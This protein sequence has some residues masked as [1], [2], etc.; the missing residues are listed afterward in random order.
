[1]VNYKVVR[2]VERF[3]FPKR[4]I[5]LTFYV[6]REQ[7]NQRF[8]ETQE[9]RGKQVILFPYVLYSTIILQIPLILLAESKRY[10]AIGYT[11]M[12]FSNKLILLL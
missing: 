1:M 8:K 7:V 5:I 12:H 3:L 6:G 4:K 9:T 10:I 2:Y 11:K